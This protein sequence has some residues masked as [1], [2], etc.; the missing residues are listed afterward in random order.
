MY[1]FGVMLLTAKS[2]WA[3]HCMATFAEALVKD[4]KYGRKTPSETEAAA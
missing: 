2:M 1:F 4:D 3:Y